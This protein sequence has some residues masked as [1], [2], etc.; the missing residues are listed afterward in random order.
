MNSAVIAI[1]SNYG[2]ACRNVKDA[3][4]WIRTNWIVKRVSHI[5]ETPDYLGAGSFYCN[6]VLEIDF[7][8]TEDSIIRKFKVYEKEKGRT[9]ELKQL[10]RV[11][12]D[13]D[14]VII[15]N[16]ILR[17]KDFET[18]YFKIGYQNLK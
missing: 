2:N 17:K 16:H 18:R 7:E 8:D 3:I 11:P 10:G 1:G 5:Y 6:A 9:D 15:N 13:I 12:I 4:S 14:L